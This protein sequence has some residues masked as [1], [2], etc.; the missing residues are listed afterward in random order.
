M[1]SNAV[2]QIIWSWQATAVSLAAL[3]GAAVLF[4]KNFGELIQEVKAVSQLILGL[5]RQ[6]RRQGMQIRHKTLLVVILILIAVPTVVFIVRAAAPLPPN[7]R[8]MSDVWN[9]F[10]KAKA[11]NGDSY[12][13]AISKA[14][15]LINEYEPGAK[16]RQK[17][18]LDGKVNVPEPGRRSEEEK[19]I[20]WSFGPLHEVS[21]AWWVK[22][23]SLEA[24]GRTPEA[25]RAYEQAAQYPH[26]LV[27]D[28]SFDGFWSPAR[29]ARARISYIR[30]K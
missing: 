6:Q 30:G 19:H 22:G 14:D 15:A 20:I 3:C 18:L 17:E 8:M 10:N 26:A 4:V 1:E 21:A 23:R 29:D 5:F 24:L 12:R 9:A 16:V 7:V 13:D 28:P 27:Y 11:K 25:I 2:L